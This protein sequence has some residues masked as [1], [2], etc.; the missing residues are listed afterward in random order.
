M[1]KKETKEVQNK[2]LDV[3]VTN[4]MGEKATFDLEKSSSIV[5]G[6]YSRALELK[7]AQVRLETNLVENHILIN[8][9]VA[10]IM[11]ELKK[12]NNDDEKTSTE[13]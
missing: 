10:K 4:D 12:D 9:Y 7:Q 3:T 13:E 2:S 11:E 8:D 6:L 5:Q 1:S